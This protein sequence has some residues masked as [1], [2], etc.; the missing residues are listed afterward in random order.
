VKC[1]RGEERVNMRN[2]RPRVTT[3]VSAI[4]IAVAVSACG[5]NGSEATSEGETA[6]RQKILV[7][8]YFPR[9][10]NDAARTWANGWDAGA[11]EV[12]EGF[13]VEQKATGKLET[14]AART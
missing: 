1:K 7:F 4:A 9:S 12:S 3:A 2:L 14:D 8:S 6:E 13:E 10:F 11:E 5:S